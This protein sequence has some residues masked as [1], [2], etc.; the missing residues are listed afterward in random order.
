[1][2]TGIIIAQDFLKINRRHSSGMLTGDFYLL[3]SVF[4]CWSG[5]M[6]SAQ[7]G[8]F[9]QRSEEALLIFFQMDE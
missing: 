5:T 8:R 1:M 6:R 9:R 3:V 2:N 7:V 4:F